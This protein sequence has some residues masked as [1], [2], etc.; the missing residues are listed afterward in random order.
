MK[1]FIRKDFLHLPFLSFSLKPVR[2]KDVEHL[3]IQGCARD[4]TGEASPVKGLQQ[5]RDVVLGTIPENVSFLSHDYGISL[6]L[7]SNGYQIQSLVL[8]LSPFCKPS[9]EIVEMLGIM[10]CIGQNREGAP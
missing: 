3:F 8:F 10:E 7:P 6:K 4:P 2:W 9:F 5:D 1:H